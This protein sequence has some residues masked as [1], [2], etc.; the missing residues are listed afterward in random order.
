M[1]RS[2]ED[3][4]VKF[5]SLIHNINEQNLALCFKELRSNA[6]CGVDEV[7][8]AEYKL[9]LAEN[10]K[11][12]VMRLKTKQYTPKAV[13]RVYIPKPGKDALRPLGIPS[14]EDKLV[15]LMLKKILE[16]IFEPR[17]K[18][19]S[20]GFRP[21]RNCH[22]AIAALD[23]VVMESPI[24]RI[25]EV[26][27][28]KFFDTVQHDWL[29][30]CVEERVADP[31]IIWLIRKFLKAGIMEAGEWRESTEGSPQ[32]GVISPLLANIYL[33]YVLDIWFDVT[34]KPITKGYVQL[35]R[36]CDDFVVACESEKDATLFLQMLE[37]RLAKFG[38]KISKEKTQTIKFGRRP[39]KSAKQQGQKLKTFDF[40]GF[41]HY[42]AA[43]KDGWFCMRHKT[44]G[45]RLS[46]MLK[47]FNDW[48][49]DVRSI[50]LLDDW[51]KGVKRRLIGHYNYFG[52]NGNMRCLRQYYFGVIRSL[53]K[54]INRRSQKHSMY[55]KKF[56][57]RLQHDPL[58]QP[59]IGVNIWY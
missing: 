8:V 48:C 50:L 47:K 4:N 40:L 1:K 38:L 59:S 51:W 21:G 7:T 12:L 11:D 28:E 45:K 41:T 17:F 14:V 52:I 32:G 42:C 13:K 22:M 53:Y 43:S 56:N 57:Q 3:K 27:I 10:I 49:R 5:V 6:A 36:Y 9:N 46:L 15:Q 20:Y 44:I 19:C 37:E 58:P 18:E 34:F 25:V 29:I 35:I 2:R 55:W 54:W 30:K 24:N 26:D 16:A 33:H 23:K 39:W 31:N